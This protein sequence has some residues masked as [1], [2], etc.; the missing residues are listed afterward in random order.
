MKK[1]TRP[2]IEMGNRFQDVNG[3]D[4]Q[5]RQQQKQPGMCAEE[6]R[7]IYHCI[8][9][10]RRKSDKSGGAAVDDIT[11]R[12][13]IGKKLG[14]QV[15]L[16][17]QA[18]SLHYW[19]AR[20]CLKLAWMIKNIGTTWAGQSRFGQG[21]T[22]FPSRHHDN[23]N[24]SIHIYNAATGYNRCFANGRSNVDFNRHTVVRLL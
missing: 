16:I 24:T 22:T 9:N 23:I 8:I 1:W 20:E 19:M 18:K 2:A 4:P 5:L 13:G 11:A 3:I 14:N 10:R 17:R 15:P 6:P 12:A 21:L 7:W